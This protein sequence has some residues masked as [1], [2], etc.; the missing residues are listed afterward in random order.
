MSESSSSN[1]GRCKLVVW[2]YNCNKD[3]GVMLDLQHT[4]DS[5]VVDVLLLQEP[6]V[7]KGRLGACQRSTR[8]SRVIHMTVEGHE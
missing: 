4:L 5:S 8:P 1:R 6:Y 3:R 2:Q 7:Y